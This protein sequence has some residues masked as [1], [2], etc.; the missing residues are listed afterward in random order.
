MAATRRVEFGYNPPAGERGIERIDPRTFVADLQRVADYASEHFDSFWSL[1]DDCLRPGG[2]VFFFDDNY[3]TEAELI[4]GTSS[5]IVERR[6]NDGTPF[7]IIKVP[8]QA[9][10]LERRLRAMGWNIAVT[11]TA[12]PFYWGMGGR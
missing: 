7:R 4:Q 5:S 2:V 9:E 12:G 10:G 11:P 8:F 1:V 3:R 6:I